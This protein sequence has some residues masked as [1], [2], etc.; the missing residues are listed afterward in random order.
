VTGWTVARS[1]GGAGVPDG[2]AVH[3][4]CQLVEVGEI[5]ASGRDA[6]VFALGPVRV[7]RRFR[8]GC[9]ASA[10]VALMA[11]VAERGYPVPRVYEVNGGD[12]V[13]ER[14]DGP[15][16]LSSVLM[17]ATGAKACGRTLA[18]LHNAL[19]AIAPRISEDP[20]DRVLHMDL[21]PDNVLLC[22]RGP[23]VI[24]WRNSTHGR[25]DLDSAVTAL[26]LAEVA[27]RD[28]PSVR[29]ALTSFLREVDG[30]PVAMLDQAVDFRRADPNLPAEEWDLVSQAADFLR[31]GA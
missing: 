26:I 23:V 2:S 1:P 27:V 12:I 9:D 4:Y 19:H 14:L 29:A 24:D 20:A 15:T 18:K 6:D 8:E 16:M 10:E 28:S 30:E 21:H 25:P 5:L 3:G 17:G 13:M 22:K 11:H 7:L 31:D